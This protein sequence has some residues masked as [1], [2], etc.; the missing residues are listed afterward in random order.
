[1]RKIIFNALLALVCLASA[2]CC[3]IITRAEGPEHQPPQY[4]GGVRADYGLMT[5]SWESKYPDNMA[6]PLFC[7][8]MPLSFCA[9][10]VCLPYDL[11]TD[12]A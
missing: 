10:I 11:H 1:M 4:F 7:I 8:D 5:L 3:S 9:D 2:G 12:H 6:V